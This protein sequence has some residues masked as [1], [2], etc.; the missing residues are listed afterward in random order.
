MRYLFVVVACVFP[1]LLAAQPSGVSQVPHLDHPLQSRILTRTQEPYG[2]FYTNT[3]TLRSS[4]SAESIVAFYREQLRAKGYR[5]TVP[6]VDRDRVYTFTRGAWSEVYL[7]IYTTRG[8]KNQTQYLLLEYGRKYFFPTEICRMQRAEKLRNFPV[9]RKFQQCLL[10]AAEQ[11]IGTA[12]YF[13][14]LSSGQAADFYKDKM[15]SYGWEFLFERTY[16]GHK[17]VALAMSEGLPSHSVIQEKGVDLA[18]MFPGADA[19]IERVALFFRQE[20]KRCAVTIVEFLDP[21]DELD[22]RR[23]VPAEFVRTYGQTMVGIEY[24]ERGK[25]GGQRWQNYQNYLNQ[26]RP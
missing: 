18:G 24:L 10:A 21:P 25:A 8:Q 7:D 11:D 4:L 6:N 26:Q 17:N 19:S 5:E 20:E 9:H 12:L 14:D 1:V 23:I 16:T 13:T 15:V 2:S 3:Y 22:A